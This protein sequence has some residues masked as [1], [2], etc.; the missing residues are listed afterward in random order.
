[1]FRPY[2][3]VRRILLIATEMRDDGAFLFKYSARP[4]NPRVALAGDRERGE[5]GEP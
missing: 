5:K 4:D 2:N 1:M 3:L